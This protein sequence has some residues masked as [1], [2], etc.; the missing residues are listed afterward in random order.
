MKRVFLKIDAKDN[1]TI[2]T[3]DYGDSIEDL[4]ELFHIMASGTEML[5]LKVEEIKSLKS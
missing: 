4:E 1:V 5:A 2:E 3:K